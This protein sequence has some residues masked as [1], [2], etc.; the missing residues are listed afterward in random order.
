MPHNRGPPASTLRDKT[1]T[2]VSEALPSDKRQ[3]TD[4]G[5]D[6]RTDAGE[7]STLAQGRW[8]GAKIEA[9]GATGAAQ[10]SGPRMSLMAPAKNAEMVESSISG[11]AMMSRE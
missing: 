10:L 2:Q 11:S 1:P 5:R 6:Q 3:N 9:I 4:A 7:A 8:A